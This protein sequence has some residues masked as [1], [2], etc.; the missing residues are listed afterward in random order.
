MQQQY[1]TLLLLSEPMKVIF[2]KTMERGCATLL[3]YFTFPIQCFGVTFSIF[4]WIKCGCVTRTQYIV[5]IFT[6][7][8][9]FVFI[10]FHGA[11][12]FF[13]DY[14][15][16]DIIEQLILPNYYTWSEMLMH[17]LL[18]DYGCDKTIDIDM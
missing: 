10:G 2:K 11:F 6:K 8:L 13:F 4:Y 16:F 9:A 1:W 5:Y 18:N 12:N 17:C 7:L 3:Y 15:E 14:H